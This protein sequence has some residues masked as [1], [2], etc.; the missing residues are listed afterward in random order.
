MSERR[1][2]ITVLTEYFHPEEAS[3]AQLLTELATGLTERFDV[4][5]VT[6]YPN[7]H[8]GD[9]S[10]SVPKQ[11]VYEGVDVRRVRATRFD[12]DAVPLR[13]VN[14]LSFVCLALGHLLGRRDR[15]D[16]V[17]VLS[18]PPILP[19]VAWV[20]KR[21]R[22]T[23]YAYLVYDVYPDVPAALGL[24]SADGLVARL[25]D[26]GMRAVYRD[27]DRIV[28]LGESME[29][30]IADKMDDDADFDPETIEVIPNW[31][32][33][34][35]IKPLEKSDNDFAREQG[36][37][38]PFT[39]VYSGNIGRFHDL[40]TAIDAVGELEAR[41]RSDVQFL[42][43]GEGARKE[44]LQR[45][46]R[47]EGVKNVRFLPFQ[48]RERL[49]ETLTCGDASLV[50]IRAEM[51]GMCVSSKLYSSLAAG[52]PVLAAVGENDE[53][54]RTV[55]SCDCGVHV[56]PGN[57][58]RAADVL[59]RWADDSERTRQLGA[60]ARRCLENNYTLSHA[61]ERYTDL[62]FELAEP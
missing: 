46:V 3:T 45:Y 1:P 37:V 59:A 47:R 60:N 57:A 20:N 13:V 61:L 15:S 35:F 62:F 9:Q 18:N 53:V 21:V 51:E 33:E 52:L 2:A 50:G 6:G 28:V 24:I 25:W 54:A 41:G 34:T 30:H 38:E 26:R 48:P 36:T 44:G 11:E 56:Q 58:E 39:L 8:E 17:L 19:L 10:R 23:P 55:R 49:P 12:K 22:G 7:Y 32:D 29:R 5:V 14:W 4:S 31:E 43:I 42:I 40:E 16:A 27:A